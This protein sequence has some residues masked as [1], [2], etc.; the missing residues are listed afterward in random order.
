M[1]VVNHITVSTAS[2][3][4]TLQPI[5]RTFKSKKRNA[6]VFEIVATGVGQIEYIW[7]KYDSF[8]NSW[9]SVSDRAINDTS[10]TLNFSEITEEDQGMYHCIVSNYDGSVSSDN[11]TI[12]VF[13]RLP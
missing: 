10:P 1:N 9:I 4:I 7:Q 6:L 12:T 2:P 13:G 3:I 11:V 5:S 8:N